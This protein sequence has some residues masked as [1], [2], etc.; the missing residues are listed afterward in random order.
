[1]DTYTRRSSG[2]L[3]RRTWH[4]ARPYISQRNTRLPLPGPDHLQ[5][6]PLHPNHRRSRIL[7]GPRLRHQARSQKRKVLPS[8]CGPQETLGHVEFIAFPIGH[9]GV[10]LA[11]TLSQLTTAFSNVRP[12]AEPTRA[13]KGITNPHTDHTAKAHDYIIF[14]SLMDSLT[15]LAQSRLIGIIRNRKRLVEALPGYISNIRACSAVDITHTRLVTPQETATH[16]HMTRK[17]RVPESTTII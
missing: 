5:Q 6:A 12:R 15:D 8:R 16:T 9:A 2:A 3:R 10:T 4:N 7:P 11:R 1:M 14:T 13:G 17:V